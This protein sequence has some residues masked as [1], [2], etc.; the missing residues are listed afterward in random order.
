MCRY[1]R[2]LLISN[3][4]ISNF[5]QKYNPEISHHRSDLF[6]VKI[7]ILQPKSCYN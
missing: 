5:Y 3:F 1:Y 2:N 6:S 7:D 4:R